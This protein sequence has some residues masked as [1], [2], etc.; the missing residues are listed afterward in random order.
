MRLFPSHS[1]S[2]PDWGFES[3]EWMVPIRAARFIGT[4]LLGPSSR[5]ILPGAVPQGLAVLW[6][7]G[8]GTQSYSTD[9]F[10]H[11]RPA[12]GPKTRVIANCRL[13]GRTPCCLGLAPMSRM[14]SA[15]MGASPTLR[16]SLLL[17][18]LAGEGDPSGV[19]GCLELVRGLDCAQ[20]ASRKLCPPGRKRCAAAVAPA[21]VA[22]VAPLNISSAATTACLPGVL[23]VQC[24]HYYVIACGDNLREA[25]ECLTHAAGLCQ[26]TRHP[27]TQL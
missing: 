15:S 27:W 17:M 7:S 24:Q 25:E 23:P 12:S 6:G 21:T 1:R 20:G 22:A 11:T 5:V 14:P 9:Q 4:L 3:R 16:F 2:L 8:G 19:W 10:H 18:L 13:G 26:A